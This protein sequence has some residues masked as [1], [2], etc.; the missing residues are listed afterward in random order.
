MPTTV[1]PRVDCTSTRFI[2]YF[3]AA[4]RVCS[5]STFKI[6]YTSDFRIR[7]ERKRITYCFEPL[8]RVRQTG[9]YSTH[10]R[11]RSSTGGRVGDVL[12]GTVLTV[13]RE[14]V[15]NTRTEQNICVYTNQR[16]V[17]KSPP[18]ENKREKKKRKTRLVRV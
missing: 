10:D 18:F 6:L 8:T 1:E 16:G 4:I 15:R 14:W 12:R 9:T 2:H 13:S 11:D 7:A 3:I 5:A 17:P